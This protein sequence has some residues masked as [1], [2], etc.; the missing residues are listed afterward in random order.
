[1]TITGSALVSEAGNGP[2][3]SK[4]CLSA[5]DA[6]RAAIEHARHLLPTQ[7]PI[8]VF[9]HHNTLH[10]FEDQPF[11][12]GIE[13]AADLFG[14]NSYLPEER[15]HAKL[16]RG[17][18]LADDIAAVLF[19]DLGDEGSTLV[20]VLGT[21]F[22]LRLAMLQYPL[23]MGADA[24][25]NWLLSEGTA[26]AQFRPQVDGGLQERMVESTQRWIMRDFR[27]ERALQGCVRGDTVTQILRAH[28]A[29]QI[30]HWSQETWK[31]VTLKLLWEICVAGVGQ[32]QATR[33]PS[34]GTARASKTPVEC[35]PVW[36]AKGGDIDRLV[37]SVLIRFCAAFLDQ[38]VSAWSLPGREQGFWKSFVGLYATSRPIERWLRGLADELQRADREPFSALAAVH[39]SLQQLGLAEQEWA[40]HVQ[41]SLLALR[42]WAGMLWQMETNAE[43]T[44]RPAPP[45]TLEQYLA[46]RLIL[47]RL[48]IQHLTQSDQAE[49]DSLSG[50]RA[51]VALQAGQKL[52]QTTI[53][54]R[55]FT[56][57][58]LAQT[59]GWKP[60]VL[61]RLKPREWA[62]LV[63]EVEAF[64]SRERRRIYH[65]AFE[66]R[67][68]NQTLD[69]LLA[70]QRHVK[71]A[72]AGPEF[73]FVCCIDDREESLRR[74][75]EET[76]PGCE[77]FG[78]AGFFG[79][80]MYY[81]GVADAHFMP[82]SPVVIK[83]RHYVQEEVV[84]SFERT[85]RRRTATRRVL[86][87]TS[88]WL[89]TGSRSV[90]GGAALALVGAAASIPLVLRV[91]FPRLAAQVNQWL[92]TFV[93]PP[94]I[95]RLLIERSEGEAG[96]E[97]GQLGYSLEEMMTISERFLRDLGLTQR[98]ASL[99]MIAGHGSACLNNPHESAYDCGACGGGRGG[100]N[101]RAIAGMLN[102]PRIRERL[103]ARGVCI[104]SKTY[105]MGAYHNTCNDE[106]EYFDLFQLPS[107]HQAIFERVKDAID[108][109]RERNAHERCR[110]FESAE[111]S[112]TPAAALR[113]VEGRA[114]DISQVRPECGHATNAVCFVGRRERTRGL[115]LDRRCFLTS[116]DPTQDDAESHILERIVQAVIPVCA[117]INLEYLFS[118]VDPAGYGCGSKL[119]HNI[120]SLLG[121]M[122]GAASDLRP[123]LPWQMVEIHEPVRILFVIETTVAAMTAVLERNPQLQPLVSHEWVQLAVLEPESA[124]MH[125]YRNG[126]FRP[127]QR[128]SSQLPQVHSSVEWYR[129]WRDH[130]GY[131]A[132]V[133]EGSER[134]GGSSATRPRGAK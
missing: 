8:R 81:R 105:F 75:L 10:A 1:M 96:P 33:H 6:L 119:P 32:I 92:S 48:A 112:L 129:G 76:L 95:T 49:S 14:C 73:Q 20:G 47:E 114:E 41:R 30:E 94:P 23:Q 80:A 111:L 52:P 97:P 122:D 86:G 34:D 77:T 72:V 123:G 84:Y 79:V 74:H 65:L 98:F 117:G 18:I 110:R 121:V 134:G 50:T 45:G 58:Q 89:H 124:K 116:Y 69:A 37:N 62:L 55:A 29:R 43:W 4:T 27:E 82:L 21:R 83:P 44:I 78:I 125:V 88:H 39:D 11:C 38:G 17:R 35:R 46:V 102:D 107:S 5:D 51:T 40:A 2:V 56:I 91:L 31:S 54:Q 64:G 71:P 113:H 70:H 36:Q 101:A 104:P 99:V 19:D 24:E 68:R 22:H 59:R 115:F 67:Y 12:Q 126:G 63:K 127:H 3:T 128:E 53:T 130:L 100:P 87:Q 103:A 109:A 118:Y 132:V 106:F 16:A 57:F 7:G 26:L 85:H 60:E 28:R 15:Y 13:Q 61:N 25:L 93:R 120:V 42:G 66:R 108:E 90:L 9:V 131:A 133:P